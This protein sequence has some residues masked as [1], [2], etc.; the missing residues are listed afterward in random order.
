MRLY[1]T[2]PNDQQKIY[3]DIKAK[4]QIHIIP[5]DI[6]CP[7]DGEIH[8]YTKDDVEAE[9]KLG[10]VAG[11]AIVGGLIGLLGGPIGVILG[12]AAGAMLGANAEDEENRNVREFY[13]GGY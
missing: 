9:P 13:E 8:H 11:G 12:G 1:V 6:E 5:F 3:V 4:H 7:Y 10:T 2:C